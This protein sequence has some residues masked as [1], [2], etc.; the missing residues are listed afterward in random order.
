MIPTRSQELHGNYPST[1]AG[2]MNRALR[3]VPRVADLLAA[4]A[5]VLVF[6]GPQLA[7]AQQAAPAAVEFRSY[8]LKPGTRDEFHRLVIA[9]L[10]L[11]ERWKIDVVGYGP[12]AHDSTSYLLIRS[13]KSVDDRAQREASFYGSREWLEGPRERVLALIESYTTV[14]LPLDSA[15][16]AG[17]RSSL[18]RAMR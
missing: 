11:L 2:R 17:L 14:V 12:S 16:V 13:F 5:A 3:G 7:G 4:G 15:T 10:P 9:T 1:K 8:N 18:A 6:T